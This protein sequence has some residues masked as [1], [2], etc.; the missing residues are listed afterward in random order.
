MAH[1]STK[2]RGRPPYQKNGAD[3]E[4]IERMAAYGITHDQIAAIVGISDETLRKYY[5]DE[6]DLGK[7]K[8]VEKVAN[9][10]V[11]VAVSGDVAAQKFFLSSRAGWAEKQQQELSGSVEVRNLQ[12][13]F[14]RPSS[15]G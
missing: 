7:A 12:V 3:A 1:A 4:R 6:L 14:V 8:T 10:L 11:D 9:S 15:K 2:A 5:R 13:E